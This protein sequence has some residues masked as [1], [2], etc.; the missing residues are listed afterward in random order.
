MLDC[1][2]EH[3]IYIYN[4]NISIAISER[5][6]Q[7]FCRLCTFAGIF[8]FIR[9]CIWLWGRSKKTINSLAL[10]ANMSFVVVIIAPFLIFV[11]QGYFIPV[12]TSNKLSSSR[13]INHVGA[14]KSRTVFFIYIYIYIG[15]LGHHPCSVESSI[16]RYLQWRYLSS[17]ILVQGCL[18]DNNQHQF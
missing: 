15:Y 17:L 10:P 18:P 9:K 8:A 16:Y 5:A 3:V 4:T 1:V 14:N 11:E 6:M 13:K 7:S 2:A 12:S